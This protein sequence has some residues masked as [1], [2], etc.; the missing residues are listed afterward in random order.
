MEGVEGE[1][2][3]VCGLG[4]VESCIESPAGACIDAQVLGK[5]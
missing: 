5:K 3:Q 4:F 1:G 2:D